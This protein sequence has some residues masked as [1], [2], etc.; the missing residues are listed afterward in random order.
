MRLSTLFFTAFAA[1]AAAQNACTGDKSIA[2]YCT[3][4][5][6]VDRTNTASGPPTVTECLDTCRGVLSDAGDWGVD[7]TGKPPGY[8]DNMLGYPCG[9][10]VGRGAGEPNDYSFLMHN[11]DI[12]DI[13]DEVNQRFGGLHGGNVAAEGTMNCEGHLATWYVN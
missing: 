7:F 1:L 13:I 6:Y 3:T 4:L 11:Q 10:S 9:F 2:G 8:I 12:I 5:T